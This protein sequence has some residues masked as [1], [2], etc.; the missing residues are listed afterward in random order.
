M[1]RIMVTAAGT[2]AASV[3]AA[4]FIEQASDRQAAMPAAAPA[5][6]AAAEPVAAVAAVPP[7]MSSHR[8]VIKAGRGGHF[9]VDGRIDG[10]P[11]TFLVD[12]GASQIAL[13]ASE[14]ARL[15][16]HIAPRDYSVRVGTAN[17]EGRAAPI[18]L[19]NLEIGSILVRDLPALVTPDEAL[20]VNLLG[21]SFLSRVRWS[22]DHG[23]LIIE[24]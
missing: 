22:H 19:R 8:F 24:Q 11:I 14:A 1:F 7:A 18:A 6:V 2:L 12:T 3:M 21:M 9:A 13:R 4:Q 16:Y 5:P 17:G 10:R 15:G 23:N 20:G